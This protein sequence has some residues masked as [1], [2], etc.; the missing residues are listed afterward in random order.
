MI[1]FIYS[2]SVVKAKLFVVCIQRIERLKEACSFAINGRARLLPSLRRLGSA[3]ASP[4]RFVV[5]TLF[6][7]LALIGCDRPTTSTKAISKES[8]SQPTLGIDGKTSKKEDAA[9]TA[10][11]TAESSAAARIL[12]DACISKYKRLQS[13]EDLGVLSIRIPTLDAKAPRVIT[14]P[15]RIAFET[16]NK[17]AIQSRTLQAMWS[18]KSNTWEAVVG[19]ENSK[20]F[21]SQR[22][23]RP[24]PDAIDLTWLIVDNL[25][26]TLNDPVIGSPIQLQLLFDEKP[27]SYLLE[28]D[29]KIALL[30]PEDF[31]S[32]KCDRIQVISKELKWVFW[33][34][35][36]KQLL[37]KYEMPTQGIEF[38][39]PGLPSDF[40]PTK[41]ELSIELVGAK[42]NPNVDWSVWNIPNQTDEIPVRR[43][44]DAPPRNTPPLVGKQLEPFD[45]IGADGKEILDS[46]Q[47]SKW[48]TVLCWVTNDEIGEKFVKYLFDIQRELDK[49]SLTKAEIILVTQAKASEMQAS[50]LKWNCSL[51]LAI[52]TQGLTQ[53]LFSIQR[54]P[55]VVVLDKK[56]RIQHFDE[57]GYLDLIP[58]V[59]ENLQLGVDIASN[60]LQNAI[61]DEA[62]F[63]SRL[64]RSMVDISQTERLAPIESFTFTYHKSKE[65]W[66]VAF[67]ETIIAASS[68]HFYPDVGTPDEATGLFAPKSKRQRITTVLDELGRVYS[69]DNSGMKNWIANI[70]IDQADN[71]K[72]MHV[73]PD[74]WTHRW[75][76]IVP[77]GLPRY[78]LIDP[79]A[80]PNE[81]PVDA[82]Q[83]DLDEDESPIA[84]AWTVK[85]GEPT[86]TIATSS[87]KLRVLDPQT[88]K[89]F[90]A[91]T[92]AITSIVPFISD[93]GECLTWIV[94]K[95]DGQIEEL[96]D[97]RSKS[98]AASDESI[99]SRIRKLTFIPR[100]SAWVWGRSR[101]RGVMLGLAQLP[102][103][104]TGTILQSRLFEPILRHPL[105]VRPEQCR[106]LSAATLVDGSF[107]WLSTAPNR[108]LHLQTGDGLVADQM[109]LG[110]RIVTAGIFPDD[111][112]LRVVLVIDK[113][114]NCWSI[115]T[116]K[117][118][119]AP[120]M[121]PAVGD[122]EA[123]N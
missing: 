66:H 117:P 17:L 37:R 113:E 97:L 34:D 95:T 89:R 87:M 111:S 35:Q 73:L 82:T 29:S 46:A 1:R 90:S 103:G 48:I 28:P 80:V 13:Y 123:V 122:R 68:E 67:D 50:L 78:W 81:E 109:S 41:A 39:V 79:T 38:L 85:D 3:G 112:N 63:N 96:E 115:E 40:D 62:R 61:H 93:R 51:P 10:E 21:G 8:G 57:F 55:A 94:V 30:P 58:N 116:P 9:P 53:K 110:K 106:I 118:A 26:A 36:E 69:V 64:H 47:R 88:K 70:P 14:E 75:I 19:K 2:F 56:V 7:C 27:L 119:P 72:R 99:L 101:N 65:A 107:Y 43:L 74:P 121:V 114:V 92:A 91:D 44:I 76:A 42:A 11:S 31:D 102:S 45:L 18:S 77:E 71:A 120:E 20:P 86:L 12:L 25:G 5:A 54:Q 59:V 100:A 22:L 104:E 32:A 33:I 49:R 84:F 6:A 15:M 98:F 24:L 83:Y 108:V 23:V 16:P 60:R 4:S 105:S 52:D